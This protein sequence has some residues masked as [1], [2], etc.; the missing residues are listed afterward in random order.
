MFDTFTQKCTRDYTATRLLSYV[1]VILT[2]MLPVFNSELV[3]IFCKQ[4]V[5]SN[6]ITANQI[7]HVFPA[8][9]YSIRFSSL[10]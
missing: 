10:K 1:D 7:V 4:H 5:D 9:I 6:I 3:F 2:L 8:G